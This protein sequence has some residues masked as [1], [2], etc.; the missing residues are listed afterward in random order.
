MDKIHSLYYF[1]DL[2][3]T[4]AFAISGATAAKQRGLD[5]FQAH[6]V[7]Q[8]AVV[9]AACA[10]EQ[11]PALIARQVVREALTARI[12]LLEVGEAAGNRVPAC[13]NDPGV[14]EDQPD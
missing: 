12:M 9:A 8:I 4:F 11:H 13:I 14:G 5:L 7:I 1:L 10:T 6:V 3:G 2:A